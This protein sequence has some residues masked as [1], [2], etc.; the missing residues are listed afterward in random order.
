MS[1]C[2]CIGGLQKLP[3]DLEQGQSP[4]I[5]CRTSINQSVNQSLNQD[6]SDL[7]AV[8]KKQ[9]RGGKEGGIQ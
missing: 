9:G 5:T 4:K 3:K 8:E 1:V 6:T 7:L 2:L